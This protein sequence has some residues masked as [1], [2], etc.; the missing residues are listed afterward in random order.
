MDKLYV[1]YLLQNPG[2]STF[3]IVENFL[4]IENPETT[5]QQATNRLYINMLFNKLNL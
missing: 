2:L 4:T 3:S 1:S 5:Q